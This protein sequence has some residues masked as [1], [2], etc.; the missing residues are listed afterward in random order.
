MGL[1]AYWNRRFTIEIEGLC[2]FLT[3][4]SSLVLTY[5]IPMNE[6]QRFQYP[7]KAAF[8]SDGE[9]LKIQFSLKSP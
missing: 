4:H 2:S 8:V 6:P 7:E 5:P 1:E 3:L 9:S